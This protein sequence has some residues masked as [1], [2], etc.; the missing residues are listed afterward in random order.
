MILFPNNTDVNSVNTFMI[1]LLNWNAGVW[2]E[3]PRICFCLEINSEA[4]CSLKPQVESVHVFNQ[5]KKD[6]MAEF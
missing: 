2:G 1:D 6:K 4:F 5:S 3:A